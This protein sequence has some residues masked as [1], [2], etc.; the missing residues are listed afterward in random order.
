MTWASKE[1]KGQGLN[2]LSDVRGG[3]GCIVAVKYQN[4]GC[5]QERK[6]QKAQRPIQEPA[7]TAFAVLPC[8]EKGGGTEEGGTCRRTG[9]LGNK[10]GGGGGGAIIGSRVTALHERK[11][12]F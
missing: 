1:K 7:E 6:V 9:W 10:G 11:K 3:G 2:L 5:K 8:G 4:T 12:R